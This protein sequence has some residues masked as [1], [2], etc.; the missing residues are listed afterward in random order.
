MPSSARSS[1]VAR[2]AMDVSSSREP[3]RLVIPAPIEIIFYGDSHLRCHPDLP[4]C[5]GY[6]HPIDQPHPAMAQAQRPRRTQQRHPLCGY[7]L[8]CFR[9]GAW[10]GSVQVPGSSLSLRLPTLVVWLSFGLRGPGAAMS[11]ER[12]KRGLFS[13]SPWLTCT[14]QQAGQ[15][16]DHHARPAHAMDADRVQRTTKPTLG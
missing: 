3:H 9:T 1:V 6:L 16:G 15:L 11:E 14:P 4:I 10:R 13:S 5:D 2:L 7:L 8:T 12:L